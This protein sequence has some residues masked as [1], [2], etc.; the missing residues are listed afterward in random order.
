MKRSLLLAALLLAAPLAGGVHAK[1][2]RVDGMP[3]LQLP[4]IDGKTLATWELRGSRV[5]YV[6][7]A[8]W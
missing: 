7:F 4:T 1:E 3:L 6:E 2:R 8:S 5:L